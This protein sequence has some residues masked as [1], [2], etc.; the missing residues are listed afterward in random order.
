MAYPGMKG[1]TS[2]I[3]RR[4]YGVSATL[5]QRAVRGAIAL[6]LS[7]LFFFYLRMFFELDSGSEPLPTNTNTKTREALSTPKVI[8]TDSSNSA[9]TGKTKIVAFSNSQ[10]RSVAKA[11]YERMSRLGYSTHVI[12]ATDHAMVDYLKKYAMR[13]DVMLH[14]PLAPQYNARPKNRKD[15]FVLQLL[16]AVRWKYLLQQLEQGYHILLTDIDNIF[17]RY[18]P[19][20]DFENSSVDVWHAY[21]TK[22][23]RKMFALQGFVVCSGMSWWRASPAGIHFSRI[24][25]KACG[26]MCDD[27]QVLNALLESDDFGMNW[28][29]TPEIK[30]SRISNGTTTTTTTASDDPRFVGLLQ[31]E[32]YGTSNVTGHRAGIWDRDFAYRGLVDPKPCPNNNWVSMPILETKSRSTA[33][34]TKAESFDVWDKNCGIGA[35]S[36]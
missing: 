10:Y 30:A 17:T 13:Y 11:W 33:W 20:E 24:M 3:N 21:A 7:I 8:S 27:Q 29:W 18:V 6:L 22:Y 32:M 25:H 36:S 31:K 15:H 4:R 5:K 19:L 14:P 26:E 35:K 16:M 2:R 1:L 23:P 12:V 34:L 28:E 9:S